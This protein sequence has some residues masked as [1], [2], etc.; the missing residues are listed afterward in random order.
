MDQIPA[1]YWT[2]G[3]DEMLRRLES[4]ASGLS[5]REARKRLERFGANTIASEKEPNAARLLL[6]QIESPMVLVL[7]FG[8]GLSSFLG[9]WSDAS[10]IL[11]IVA[12]SAGLGFSQEYRASK[13]LAE[14]KHRLA[15]TAKVKRDGKGVTIAFDDIVPG[16]IVLLTAG[17]VV[18]ADGVILESTDCLVN[19]A[20][21]TGESAP[22][23][24][25]GGTSAGD[26]SLAQRNNCLFAGTSL[27]SGMAALLVVAT[28]ADT[29]FGGVARSLAVQEPETE[30]ERGVRRFG[31]M[32]IRVMIIMVVFV[33]V[34]SEALGRPL[35]ES[36]LFAVALAVGM[37]PELLPAIVTV[38]L[39]TGA[40][41]MAGGG[42]IVRRL[43]AIEN[44][45]SI[46]IL[47]TD[48]TGTLTMGN[49]GL[50]QAVDC[51]GEKSHDVLELAF[52]N[53]SFES[54]IDNPMDEAVRN[55]GKKAG[56][57]TAGAAKAGEIPYDFARKR[58]TVAIGGKARADTIH[59]V[60]KGAFKSVIAVCSALR[61]AHEAMTLDEALRR[62]AVEYCDQKG[63]EGFRV[64]ALATKEIRTGG[65]LGASIEEGMVLEGFLLFADP[66]KM[67]A[68][69][70]I[71]SLKDL[72]IQLKMISGDSREVCVHVGG[73]LGLPTAN[74]VTGAQLAQMS[75]DALLHKAERTSLFV[76]VDPAQKE[77]IIRALQKSGHAVGYL[78]D[79]INDSPALRAADVGISVETAVDVARQSADIVLLQKNLDVLRTGIEIGRRSFAN[80]L[81]YI[82]ITISANFGNM[83]S[84]AVATP[85]L[86][87]LP[88]FAKQILL[89][90]FL[91]DLPSMSIASDN[92][93]DAQVRHAER[94][95]VAGV[96][97][98][99]LVFGLVSSV[100]D[101]ATFALLLLVYRAG[102]QEFQ[103]AW[104][105]VSL[106]TEIAVVLVL[107][108]RG[109]FFRSR[110]SGL[111]IAATSIVF[112]AALTIP[113]LG[114]AADLFGFVPLPPA[115]MVYLLLIVAAYILVTEITKHLYYAAHRP[116]RAPA[117]G[118]RVR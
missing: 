94:W 96:R 2:L 3:P 38:T 22:V 81:K 99:M 95:D 112:I 100:F 101:L 77:R 23:E 12:A 102:E 34:V 50:A 32:L 18:P 13:A 105:I 74:V 67:D 17:N 63:R 86:P 84:M 33:L 29:V 14:L 26:A 46:D 89:N 5:A 36:L 111:L 98:F 58:L 106:L 15:L 79:G 109:W 115:L 48:K 70:A 16:D 78:G 69:Q 30:F 65:P 25:R 1:H 66:P 107:R 7:L 39:A 93:D 72:G 27:R 64:L 37:T 104:F 97:R 61:S 28:R 75:E 10:I 103:T 45:G 116:A 49:V 43:E 8:A 54:G 56:L 114:K 59:L 44:L 9:E 90:N 73:Q 40:R 57:T 117:K 110:A 19:E 21:L 71:A 113:Y 62:Q 55:A 11:A 60:T 51:R 92:V 4:R 85:L 31:Y 68:A 83:L 80:T 47:C 6:R 24:K 108:T 41:R 118:R 87:F 76:E 20:P 53:S 35:V 82:S 52:L 88:L 91:S 42:V